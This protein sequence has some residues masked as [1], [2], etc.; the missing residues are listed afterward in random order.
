MMEVQTD[1]Y[2]CAA[3][4]GEQDEAGFQGNNIP[5]SMSQLDGQYEM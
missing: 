2:G 1:V 4:D 3:H 5:K